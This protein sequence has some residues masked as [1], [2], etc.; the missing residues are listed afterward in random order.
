[1]KKYYCFVFFL[2]LNPFLFSQELVLKVKS[3]PNVVGWIYKNGELENSYCIYERNYL[4]LASTA[5]QKKLSILNIFKEHSSPIIS[6][7]FSLSNM[8]F[9]SLDEEGKL[10][11]RRF[12]NWNDVKIQN[13][14]KKLFPKSVAISPDDELVI[15]G[16]ENGFLQAHFILKNAKKDF[17]AYFKGHSASIYS[18]S[19]NAIGKCFLTSG[20]DE[21]VK[22]WDSKTLSLLNEFDAFTNNLCP[23][24]FSPIEDVF[25]Y[26]TSEKLL[27][28]CDTMGNIKNTIF[29]EDGIKLAKFTEKKDK[30]AILTSKN[31]MEFYSISN[32]RCLGQMPALVDFSINSFDVNI[33][34]GDILLST[35]TGEIYLASLHDI[36][37]IHK[38]ERG[39]H[40]TQDNAD[41][42]KEMQEN[43]EDEAFEKENDELSDNLEKEELEE[44]LEEINI[45]EDIKLSSFRL[46]EETPLDEPDAFVIKKE[47]K[48]NNNKKLNEIILE[49]DF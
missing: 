11:E 26:C 5:K 16:F 38:N 1:M 23:A 24:F 28:V 48:K 17:S 20:K 12:D 6:S 14:N 29:V 43:S 31:Q 44:N 32:G 21:K 27:S 2:I 40:S 37:K 19:F 42:V 30:I 25:V 8:K 36:K 4:I 46:N 39:K 13:L 7:N 33:I 47:K 22:L 41:D 35:S 10:I 45:I 34:K 18:I 9:V 15:V 3:E 49:D